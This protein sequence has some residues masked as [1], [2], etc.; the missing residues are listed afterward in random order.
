MGITQQRIWPKTA[1]KIYPKNASYIKE[2]MKCETIAMSL[3]EKNLNKLKKKKKKL[4]HNLI[5]KQIYQA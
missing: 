5:S 2:L 1:K 4:H 3:R